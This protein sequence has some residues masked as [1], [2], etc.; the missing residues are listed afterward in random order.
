VAAMT[1]T[2]VHR[3]FLETFR[4]AYEARL[5]AEPEVLDRYS[6]A[7]TQIASATCNK[8]EAATRALLG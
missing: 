6:G 3:R 2:G 7:A 4:Q 1:A 5:S 8:T